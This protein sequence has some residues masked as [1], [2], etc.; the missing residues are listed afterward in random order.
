MTVLLNEWSILHSLRKLSNLL[1]NLPNKWY[2]Y[3][4]PLK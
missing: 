1:G 3:Y 4:V 2:Q